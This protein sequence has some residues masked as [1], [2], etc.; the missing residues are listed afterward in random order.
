[1]KRIKT[2][3]NFGLLSEKSLS[4]QH[5]EKIYKQ[6]AD[7]IS[8]TIKSYRSNLKMAY[9]RAGGNS[10]QEEFNYYAYEEPSPLYAVFNLE[11]SIEGILEKWR[12]TD[13]NLN[14]LKNYLPKEDYQYLIDEK[15]IK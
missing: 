13:R 8:N 15:I 14:Q 3:E 10:S 2:F 12:R 5:E 7:T 9:S 4:Q 11:E 6:L 1:M